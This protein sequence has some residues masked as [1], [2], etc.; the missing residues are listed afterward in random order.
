MKI[1]GLRICKK[2]K[3]FFEKKEDDLLISKF[4]SLSP[5]DQIENGQPYFDALNWALN[6]KNEKIKNIALAGTYGSGKSSIIQSFQ[7][8]NTNKKLHFLN[9]SLATFKEEEKKGKD[10]VVIENDT[11]KTTKE[12]DE[13]AAENNANKTTGENLLRLIE[14]SILQQLFYREK[15]R[16]LPDSRLK[17]IKSFTWKNLLLT[18]IGCF[19]FLVSIFLFIKPDILSY[20]LPKVDISDNIKIFIHY[21]SLTICVLGTVFI[22]FKSIRIFH[23]LNISK[24][25]IKDAEIEINKEINKSVLNHNLE[26]I[27]YFFEVTNYN[28]VIIEDLDRFQETEIFTKLREINLLINNSKKTN[29]RITFIYAIRDEMFADK[30]RTKFFDF[31]VPVI[32][33][34][35]TSNSNEILQRE[36]KR[37]A[38]KVSE[39]LI[40]DISLFID[41][42]RLLYNIINEFQIYKQLLSEE[43]IQNKLLAMIVYKNICPCDFVKLSDYQGNLYQIINNKAEYIKQQ[44]AEFDKEISS[45]KEE[46]KQLESLKI[47]DIKELRKLYILE[48]IKEIH[49]QNSYGITAFNINDV[50]KNL[51][52]ILEDESFYCLVESNTLYFRNARSTNY[53]I[54]LKFSDIENRVDENHNYEE[55]QQQI[56]DWNNGKVNT[57][58]QK[59]EALNQ[60]KNEIRHEKLQNL[61][62]VGT[63]QIETKA[64]QQILINLL[65]RNGY[66]AEDYL[67]YISLFHEGSISKND[68]AFLLNVKSGIKTD[69]AHKLDKIDKLIEKININDFGKEYILNNS[70]V[71]FLLDNP[72][73]YLHYKN[74]IFNLLANDSDNSED[75]ITSF[76]FLNMIP[77]ISWEDWRNYWLPLQSSDFVKEIC[78]YWSN[79]WKYY[80]AEESNKRKLVFYLIIQDANV[81]DIKAIADKSNL[82]QYISEQ[83]EFCDIIYDKEK[84]KQILKTLDIKFIDLDLTATS[85]DLLNY[86]IENNH[87]AIN[88]PMFRIVLPKKIISNRTDINIRNYYAIKNSNCKYLIKYIDDNISEYIEN[89][90]LKLDENKQEDEGS[91]IQLLNNENISDELKTKIIQKVETKISSLSK[92]DTNPSNVINFRYSSRS[93]NLSLN[94]LNDLD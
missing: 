89:I 56:E 91:L 41:E 20:I 36:I 93:P 12:K 9:I 57:L 54:Q 32:P 84:I 78:S 6:I 34:I 44:I 58:K 29:R 47:K 74:A 37:I 5:T 35:N 38:D 61:I 87:Y 65:L 60:K 79:I 48:Y 1:K 8:Q 82:K 49:K 7:K 52:Q 83:K 13:I 62:Q 11:N 88:I 3:S 55:R 70:L 19:L 63:L 22:L 31:I 59:I 77:T 16:K 15:D 28:I 23:N 86:I 2:I 40:D 53:S 24:L 67:D 45:C 10:E 21:L 42:M 43:L 85:D 73:N 27:L 64:N 18:T 71:K 94:F 25:N 75:F 46:I 33:I 14:L 68:H 30:D 92:I 90:Y 81:T 26:E 66:I 50:P 72:N 51:D 69:F 39:T 4:Y 80:S 17:K 76:L